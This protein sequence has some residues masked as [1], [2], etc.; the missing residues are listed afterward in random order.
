MKVNE[1]WAVIS[2][3]LGLNTNCECKGNES[4]DI[5][6]KAQ[7]LVKANMLDAK[8]LAAIQ[9]MAPADRELMAAFIGALGGTEA[10]EPSAEAME[11]VIEETPEDMAEE[12]KPAGMAANKKAAAS[13]TKAQIDK[14]VANGVKEHLRRHTVVAQLTA[15]TANKLTAKQMDS[16]SVDQLEAVEQMIRPADYSGAGG[17]ATNSSAADIATVT[18]LRPRGVLVNTKKDK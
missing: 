3:S 8:Q 15:N 1:A 13:F 9:K 10:E 6:K 7:D 17:F 11:E 2:K 5:L 12:E 16:M 18:P 14:L 4:M